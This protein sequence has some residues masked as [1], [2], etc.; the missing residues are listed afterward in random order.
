MDRNPGR[1]RDPAPGRKYLAAE[2]MEWA[3]GRLG[4]FNAF[5]QSTSCRDLPRGDLRQGQQASAPRAAVAKH[6]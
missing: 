5:P 4:K 2:L 1:L 6:S 3:N